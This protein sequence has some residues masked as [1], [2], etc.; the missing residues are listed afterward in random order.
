MKSSSCSD[1]SKEKSIWSRAYNCDVCKQ[2]V[3][4][5]CL[6]PVD[7]RDLCATQGICLRC[8]KVLTDSHLDQ[9]YLPTEL[10]IQETNLKYLSIIQ[11]DP[12]QDFALVSSIGSGNFS[13]VFHVRQK[14]SQK[15]YALK[16]LA[17]KYTD[18]M[19][20]NNEFRQ[21]VGCQSRNIL[22]NFALY[23]NK[24]VYYI[25]QELMHS[26][27]CDFIKYNE[28]VPEEVVLYVL[29]EILRG[30]YYM[31]RNYVVHRDIKS[32]NIFLSFEGEVKIGDFGSVAQLTEERE[33]RN[34]L[35]GT[36]FYLA[37]EIV[38]GDNYGAGVDVWSLGILAYE[39]VFKQPLFS[40]CKSFAELFP[41]IKN[42]SNDSITAS[43][44]SKVND[45]V[46][47]CLVTNPVD[48]QSCS[49]LLEN[50]IFDLD[51]NAC[52]EFIMDYIT[53]NPKN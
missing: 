45:F 8:H 2:E 10:E 15:D 3:C 50:R 16:Q 38:R 9:L 14:D 11:K 1:C 40:E 18:Q 31:H 20:V 21:S 19:Q 33:I 12:F 22:K 43:E 24:G 37:P 41:K 7:S 13:T 29:R 26:T 17:S 5:S 30:L 23:Q 34:T 46:K 6:I 35:V 36:P 28:I 39:L 47:L 32:E 49:Q 44:Y 27:V 48:R 51:S 25:L 42:F 53:R 4:G 52:K